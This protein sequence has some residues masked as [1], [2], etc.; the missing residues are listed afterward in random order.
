MMETSTKVVNSR[1]H[2][3]D[4]DI[5]HSKVIF[6]VVVVVARPAVVFR[7]FLFFFL[8]RRPA[9]NALIAIVMEYVFTKLLAQWLLCW[10]PKN[11]SGAHPW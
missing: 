5:N 11:T 1:C 2:N 8:C 10:Y 7:I 4:G 3:H 9:V 6:S